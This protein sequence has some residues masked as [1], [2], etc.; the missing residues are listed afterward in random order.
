MKS[1]QL[2]TTAELLA[3]ETF[4]SSPPYDALHAR[5]LPVHV[6]LPS[7]TFSDLSTGAAAFSF[8][9]SAPNSTWPMV[10]DE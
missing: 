10:G 4:S 1:S 6:R 9:F 7:P 2:P 3:P 8:E 5:V